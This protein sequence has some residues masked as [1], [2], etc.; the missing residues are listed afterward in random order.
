M[1]VLPVAMDLGA[2]GDAGLRVGSQS[3][4][5]ERLGIRNL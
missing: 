2:V 3:K 4:G 1:K 5:P